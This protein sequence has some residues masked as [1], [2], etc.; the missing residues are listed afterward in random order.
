M[1]T[2]LNGVRLE[3]GM[4]LVLGEN[5]YRFG[6]GRITVV[7]REVLGVINVDDT[8]WVEI[9]VCQLVAG[10]RF[11]RKIEVRLDALRRPR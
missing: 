10:G 4:R 6:A 3:P 8:P 11:E 5:D 2:Y 7:I 1:A 9:D